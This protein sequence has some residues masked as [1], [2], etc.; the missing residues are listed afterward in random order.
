MFSSRFADMEQQKHSILIIQFQSTLPREKKTITSATINMHRLLLIAI[1]CIVFWLD[2]Q[3]SWK[4]CQTLSNQWSASWGDPDIYNN[5]QFFDL[6]NIQWKCL[7]DAK[8]QINNKGA[9]YCVVALTRIKFRAV[10]VVFMNVNTYII[11]LFIFFM[12]E[13]R[14]TKPTST[15]SCQL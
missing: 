2:A 7:Y 11:N 9:R 14:K 10:F 8:I 3:K 4:T 12:S 15:M 13:E 6:L 5:R 1:G